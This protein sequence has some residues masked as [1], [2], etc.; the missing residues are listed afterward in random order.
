MNKFVIGIISGLALAAFAT[1]VYQESSNNVQPEVAPTIIRDIVRVPAMSTVEAATHRAQRFESLTTVEETLRLPSDF[2]QTEALYVL[3]GRSDSAGVQ[4]LIHQTLRVADA[5][6]RSAGL[7]ILFSRLTDIDPHSAVAMAGQS[8]FRAERSI[9]SAIWRTWARRDLDKALE[10]VL[11]LSSISRRNDAAQVIYGAYGLAENDKTRHIEEVLGVPPSSWTK[12][13][14]LQSLAADSPFAAVDYL[15]KLPLEEQRSAAWSLGDYIGRA[16][17][18]MAES[19]ISMISNAATRA[20]YEQSIYRAMGNSDPAKL[21]DRW[22]ADPTSQKYGAGV[23]TAIAQLAQSDFEQAMAYY[24]ATDNLQTRR[25]FGHAIIQALALDDPMRALDWARQEDSDG[26]RSLYQQAIVLISQANPEVAL[27]AAQSIENPAEKMS[28]LSNIIGTLANSDPAAAVSAL[29]QMPD[30]DYKNQAAQRLLMH[31]VRNDAAAATEWAIDNSERYG[32]HLLSNVASMLVRQ[33]PQAAINLL[34]RL[35]EQTANNLSLQIV[36]SLADH[37]S[38]AAAE[39]FV[40]AYKNSPQ[41]EQMYAAL[42]PQIV[43]Q[44]PARAVQIANGMSPGTVRDNVYAQLVMQSAQTSPRQAIAWIDAIDD[45]G[46]R[47]GA[48]KALTSI[49]YRSDPVAANRWVSY[50]PSGA[51]RDDAIA[52]M[53][54]SSQNYSNTQVDLINSIDDPAK[55]SQALVGFVTQLSRLDYPQAMKLLESMQLGDLERA[56]IKAVIQNS[57]Q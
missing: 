45:P 51:T 30:G 25:A 44:D 56:Q 15:N 3:A 20:G 41:Y 16:N 4:D 32:T 42:I 49:W 12:R 50:L 47:T 54:N 43:Q 21:L 11:N 8:P 10:A 31:W 27:A 29:D 13:Q 1:W 24:N 33:D 14:Y 9:E 37:Q 36:Q 46:S 26:R 18:P 55:R 5:S 22:L 52:A 7:S 2:D 57:R 28:T 17:L 48:V 38:L 6:D 19:L 23:Q 35:D 53:I 34:P 40:A 39:S